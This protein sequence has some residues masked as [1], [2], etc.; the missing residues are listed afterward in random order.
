MKCIKVSKSQ[1]L[2]RNIEWKREKGVSK[3]EKT[4]LI[5]KYE[6]VLK[7]IAELGGFITSKR[8]KRLLQYEKRATGVQFILKRL[9]EKGVF[10]T[11]AM[12]LSVSEEALYGEKTYIV[13]TFT[14]HTRAMIEG[15]EKTP[16]KPTKRAV[17]KQGYLI[18]IFCETYGRAV[19]Q[20]SKSAFEKLSRDKQR[21][22]LIDQYEASDKTMTL[23]VFINSFEA[24]DLLS[25]GKNVSVYDF[26]MKTKPRHSLFGV[27]SLSRYAIK[28]LDGYGSPHRFDEERINRFCDDEL[29]S[30]TQRIKNYEKVDNREQILKTKKKIDLLNEKIENTHLYQLHKEVVFNESVNRYEV[31]QTEKRASLSDFA[32]NN[33]AIK[34]FKVSDKGISFTIA[35]LDNYSRKQSAKKIA[36]RIINSRYLIESLLEYYGTKQRVYVHYELFSYRDYGQSHKEKVK[37]ILTDTFDYLEAERIGKGLKYKKFE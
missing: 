3:E 25:F 8:L 26:L 7:L 34:H 19:W 29:A 14:R 27:D 20:S 1:P 9:Y 22:I 11:Y 24:Y 12:P 16:K 21:S 10:N 18:E 32:Y 6:D 30:L 37:K 36:T 33:L 4:A 17:I 13:F 2:A 15:T 35:I 5:K 31:R 28:T 23:E